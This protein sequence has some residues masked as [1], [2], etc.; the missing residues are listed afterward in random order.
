MMTI[1]LSISIDDKWDYH[2]AIPYKIPQLPDGRVV[3][4]TAP[5]VI[6]TIA[7]LHT[8][9]DAYKEKNQALVNKILG[10]YFKIAN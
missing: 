7:D 6:V 3:D 10:S 8:V 4:M 1:P 2:W 5:H 9:L